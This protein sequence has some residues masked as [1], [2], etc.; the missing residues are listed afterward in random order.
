MAIVGVFAGAKLSAD[1]ETADDGTTVYKL[2]TTGASGGGA[3][4]IADGAD[5]AEGA[6]T[7]AVVAAG[8]A[9]TLSAKLRRLTTDIGALILQIPASLGAKT[10]AL[11][12]SVVPNTDTNFPV[13]GNVLSAAADSG[14]PVK[15][16]GKYNS[17][18]PTLTNGN[19]GDLQLAANGALLVGFGSRAAG[20]NADSGSNNALVPAID[21]SGVNGQ[22][23]TAGYLFNGA[24]WDRQRGTIDTAA[25]ITLS[26]AGAGT[27]NSADQTNYSARGV[28]VGINISASSGTI[29][30]V[31]N[32]Q[33]KD[34][35]SGT[36][37]T[38]AS[39]AAL[40]GTGFVSLTVYPGI[41]AAANS[42][43]ADVLPRTWRVQVVSGAGVTP[44]V[45]A[46]VGASII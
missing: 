18:P 1:T 28:K 39:T 43:V 25:L 16:G 42:A 2:R 11:S 40:V 30:V 17:T 8:A 23:M 6:T 15:A 13:V 22:L 29:S 21:L 35:A 41:T 32:I 34:A 5:V 10:G 24:T 33:G 19:R 26:A 45:T 12:L 38:I 27:T 9:G 36:Y 4:T 20:L 3:A 37:Y 14:A 31:V 7:D 46:T 44:S